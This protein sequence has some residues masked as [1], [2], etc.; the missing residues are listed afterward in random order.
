MLHQPGL[1]T[2]NL[3]RLEAFIAEHIP[4]NVWFSI[5]LISEREVS[6]VLDSLNANKSVGLDGIHPIILKLSSPAKHI[7]EIINKSINSGKCPDCLKLAKVLA[8]HKGNDTCNPSNYRPISILPA[9]SKLFEKHV[10]KHLTRYLLKHQLLQSTQSGLRRHHSCITALTKLTDQWLEAIDSGYIT[11]AL[12]LDFKKISL[13]SQV[14]GS[15]RGATWPD[16][17]LAAFFPSGPRWQMWLKHRA[18]YY[19]PPTT[20]YM[21]T[22][23]H[24]GKYVSYLPKVGGF[25]RVLRFPPPIKLTRHHMTLDVESGVKH[26]SINQSYLFSK[27]KWMPIKTRVTY[28]KGIMIFK[29]LNCKTPTY[30]SELLH[31]KSELTNRSLRSTDN[32]ELNIPRSYTNYFKNSFSISAPTFWNTLPISIRSADSIASFKLSLKNFL[33]N[34]PEETIH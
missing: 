16:L 10:S 5:P 3:N 2:L 20:T 28:F 19:M 17:K 18:N 7:S 31:Y 21:F 6:R 14:E 15:S 32:K 26:Q 12:F 11:G 23:M 13:A 9:V 1:S 25:P 24:D 27:L 29:S 8:L 34:N 22:C 30:I 4:D 33:L